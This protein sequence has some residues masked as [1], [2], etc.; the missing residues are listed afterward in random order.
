MAAGWVL[1]AVVP[2]GAAAETESAPAEKIAG[3][4]QTQAAVAFDRDPV[5]LSAGAF[6]VW[7]LS[8]S[9]NDQFLAASGGGG[10]SDQNPGQARVWDF[11]KAK[12]VASYPTQRGDLSVALS[13]DGRR[14]ALGSW[15]GEIWLREVGGAELLQGQFDAHPRLAFSPDGK[16]LVGASERGQLRTWDGVT[17]KPLEEGR[18]PFHG[19]TFPFYWVGFS[20]DGKYLVAAG[21]KKNRTWR[22]QVG[23]LGR[24][25]AAATL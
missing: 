17:G 3:A 9:A 12:E 13:P 21:G 15:S 4:S 25:D 22:K 8:F 16:L 6:D 2:I 20:P 19:G 24:G 5:Q 10:W 11:A 7:S 18:N 14:V 1:A 23:G